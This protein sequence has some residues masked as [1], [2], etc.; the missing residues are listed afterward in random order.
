MQH[1]NEGMI[2]VRTSDGKAVAELYNDKLISRINYQLYRAVP[3]SE[4]LA[5]FNRSIQE[6]Q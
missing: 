5:Q 4:Y 2:I 3:A 1:P 6:T